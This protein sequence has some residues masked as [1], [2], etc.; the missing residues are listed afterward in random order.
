MWQTF[1]A[2]TLASFLFITIVL[3]SSILSG[4]FAPLVIGLALA[5]IIWAFSNISTCAV[6]PAI[7]LSM[8]LRGNMSAI[9]AMLYVAAELLGAV[10]AYLW[11]ANTYGLKFKK[12]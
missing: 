3:T 7:V 11:W 8:Y 12:P 10:L 2:E 9:T 1:I 6:N 4:Q 5:A